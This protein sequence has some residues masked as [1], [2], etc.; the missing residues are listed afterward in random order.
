[1]AIDAAVQRILDAS[2]AGEGFSESELA[3]LF[4]V[5]PGSEEHAA[6]KE[7]RLELKE[8]SRVAR[9]GL[10]TM[11]AQI[12]VDA[13]TAVDAIRLRV[14]LPDLLEQRR[15]ALRARTRR[16]LAPGVVTASRDAVEAAHHPHIVHV[17]VLLYER[18]DFAFRSVYGFEEWEF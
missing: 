15:V 6:M 17:P 14:H 11:F 10:G 4:K 12:G 3:Y 8:R 16:S 9:G 18:E 2:L 1:M 13:R 7:V 5:K